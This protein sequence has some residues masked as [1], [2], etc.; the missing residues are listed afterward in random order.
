MVHFGVPNCQLRDQVK[1]FIYP[2]R[3][4]NLWEPTLRKLTN[5]WL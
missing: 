2:D 3:A 1:D 5:N 4:L